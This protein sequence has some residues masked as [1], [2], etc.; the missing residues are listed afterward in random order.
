MNQPNQV[1]RLLSLLPLLMLPRQGLQVLHC[2][3]LVLR[4]LP[5]AKSQA[6]WQELQTQPEPQQELWAQP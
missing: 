5:L 4:Q 2:W 3:V 6:R 1:L